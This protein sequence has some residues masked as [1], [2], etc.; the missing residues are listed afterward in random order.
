MP[1]DSGVTYRSTKAVEKR[2]P[3]LRWLRLKRAGGDHSLGD[4]AIRAVS[5]ILFAIPRKTR[6]L[7]FESVQVLAAFQQAFWL[8]GRR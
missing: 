1:G 6:R 5:A 7:S 8:L 3:A 4:A 2:I